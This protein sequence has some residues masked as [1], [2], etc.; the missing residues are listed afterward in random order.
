M[1]LSSGLDLKTVSRCLGHASETITADVYTDM[2]QVVK[3]HVLDLK[4]WEEELIYNQNV[5]EYMITDEMEKLLK[6]V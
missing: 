4:P 2:C 5:S 3:N 6:F 1:L